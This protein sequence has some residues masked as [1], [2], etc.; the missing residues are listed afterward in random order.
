MGTPKRLAHTYRAV[1]RTFQIELIRCGA[2]LS[3]TVSAYFIK[4]N[5]NS[6]INFA[7]GN[8]QSE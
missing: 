6:T 1:D 4:L 3:E 2:E 5:R 8:S 7:A